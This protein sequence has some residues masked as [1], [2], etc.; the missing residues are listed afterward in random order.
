[1]TTGTVKFFNTDKGYGFIEPEDGSKDAVVH[2]SDALVKLIGDSVPSGGTLSL[3]CAKGALTM[4]FDGKKS[5]L[6]DP[7]LCPALLD[8]YLGA[9]P[10]SGAAKDGVARSSSSTSF[11]ALFQ[12]KSV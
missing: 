2:P 4:A 11:F 3:G 1:M 12:R 9:S 6:K 7:E 10:I 5:T 8:V